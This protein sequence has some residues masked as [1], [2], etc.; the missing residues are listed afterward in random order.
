MTAMDLAF[1][2]V[3]TVTAGVRVAGATALMFLATQGT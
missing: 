3:P 2:L 1:G